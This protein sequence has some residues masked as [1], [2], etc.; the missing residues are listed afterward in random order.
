MR[1]FPSAITA[2]RVQGAFPCFV[3]FSSCTLSIDRTALHSLDEYHTYHVSNLTQPTGYRTPRATR[4]RG[5]DPL[6]VRRMHTQQPFRCLILTSHTGLAAPPT[7]P[8]PSPSPTR[9]STLHRSWRPGSPSNQH[10]HHNNTTTDKQPRTGE[11]IDIPRCMRPE[12]VRG[13][14]KGGQN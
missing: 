9:R 6:L 2:R 5:S 1:C 7:R 12:E 14:L 8:P 10:Q 11:S 4:P 13:W 3:R